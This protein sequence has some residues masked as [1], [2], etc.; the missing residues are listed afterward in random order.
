MR[1]SLKFFSSGGTGR[2]SREISERSFYEGF[3]RIFEIIHGG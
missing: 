3:G 1:E 2:I